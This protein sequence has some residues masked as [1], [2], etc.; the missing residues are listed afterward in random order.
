M[1]SLRV[2]VEG[3]PVEAVRVAFSARPGERYL[4]FGERSN[5]VDQR[6]RTS[7][8]T[9]PTGPTRPEDSRC[10]ASSP[11][12]LPRA[13]SDATYF[14]IPWLLSTR[15]YGVLVDDD[16]T[17]RLP[18]R[19]RPGRGAWTVEV[20]A[21]RIACACS[22]ARVPPT[23]CAVSARAWVAS[24]RPRHRST[25]ARGTSRGGDERAEL[26]LLLRR[27][28]PLSVAQTYTHYLPCGDQR[29]REAASASAPPASTPQGWP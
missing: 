3:R 20:E 1:V 7:R 6:G 11:G 13:R 24:R 29:G 19:P 2:E 22:P 14:P 8:A 10:L 25:S 12:R 5:A 16:E 17:S 4:G 27:D 28:V 9:C 23:S 18:A 26:D 21:P 15:G